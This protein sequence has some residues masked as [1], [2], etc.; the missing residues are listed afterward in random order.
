M[1]TKFSFLLANIGLVIS[2]FGDN[3]VIWAWMILAVMLS[4][5]WLTQVFS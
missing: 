4:R 5:N 2:L 3:G 1:L